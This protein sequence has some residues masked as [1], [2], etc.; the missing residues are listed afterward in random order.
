[1]GPDPAMQPGVFHVQRGDCVKSSRDSKLDPELV[2]KKAWE[3][4]TRQ[5]E[6]LI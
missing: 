6:R 3:Y 1:M 4:C 2:A 5:M